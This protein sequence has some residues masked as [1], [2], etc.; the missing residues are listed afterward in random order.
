MEC[1]QKL[2]NISSKVVEK[3]FNSIHKFNA[4]NLER[5]FVNF[6]RLGT[7]Q[8]SHYQGLLHRKD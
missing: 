8:R 4:T 5:I 3:Y 7:D 6:G 1:N 2:L